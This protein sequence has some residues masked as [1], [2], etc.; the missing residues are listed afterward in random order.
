M[1]QDEIVQLDWSCISFTRRVAT[2][3]KTKG[4]KLRT[5]PLNDAALAIWERQPKAPKSQIVFWTGD[6]ATIGW[7]SNV[8]AKWSRKLSQR[9]PDFVRFGFHDL[10]HLFV[11]RYL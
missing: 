5:V 3:H 2:I 8:F 7:V 10:R 6:G 11:V 1:R 9:K 4:S